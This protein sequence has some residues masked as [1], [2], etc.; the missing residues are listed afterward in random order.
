MKCVWSI[1][2]SLQKTSSFSWLVIILKIFDYIVQ[3][4]T[5]GYFPTLGGDVYE[6]LDKGLLKFVLDTNVKSN[7]LY[8]NI[9]FGHMSLI[10]LLDG[11]L[12]KKILLHNVR[13]GKIYEQRLVKF[14]G[15]G[16]FTSVDQ[17]LWSHQRSLIFNVFRMSV[18]KQ[19]TPKLTECMFKE[20]DD[21]ILKKD[22]QD[23]VVIL[24]IIGLV[25]FC[26][27]LFG[28]DVSSSSK[29]LIEPLNNILVFINNS[30][31]PINNHFDESYRKFV[32][33]K[34]FVHKW[35]L[36]LITNAKKSKYCL[37][38]I[39][40]ELNNV[41]L[42]QQQMIEFVLSIVLGGHETTARLMLGIIYSVYQNNIII[43]KLNQ[44][45]TNYMKNHTEYEIDIL[46]RPYLKNI[47]R[48]GA[49]LFPPV[50]L[51]SRQAQEDIKID[52][53]SFK[54]GTE[55]LISPLIFLRD[56]KIWGYDSENF[57]PERFD[58]KI[59]ADSEA[60]NLNIPF[61]IGKE[62]CPGKKFAELETAIVISKLFYEYEIKIMDHNL[63]PMSA[64]TF[65]LTD[66]LPVKLIKK[67]IN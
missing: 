39:Q 28:V 49:R 63:N 3:I 59:F 44:E 60:S 43:D 20:L 51:L 35:M 34:K 58:P 24:S 55:F 36:E 16:I 61:V 32:H 53:H 41:N 30:P 46:Y 57:D 45:T 14:F 19:I 40:Q 5:F 4:L 54:S 31:D 21:L 67:N 23:L 50:W 47:I 2:N 9:R 66:N 25:G 27:T 22:H 38:V 18:L 12:S 56:P 29:N 33:D 52:E 48:E 7:N 8:E 65:R 62:N 42:T 15:K 37:P 6:L 10:L 1:K 64:G 13:R 11:K 17:N 26:K